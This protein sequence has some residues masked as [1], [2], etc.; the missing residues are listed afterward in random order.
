MLQNEA[1]KQMLAV[2]E[3]EL[4]H[5]EKWMNNIAIVSA[6]LVGCMSG[7]LSIGP[8]ELAMDFKTN[9]SFLVLS[10]LGI[11]CGTYSFSLYGHTTCPESF[12]HTQP[13]PPC[14]SSFVALWGLGLALGGPTGSV[15]KV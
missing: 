2:R 11:G 1:V 4:T 14:R 15:N 6:L 10:M 8:S 9:V 7:L 5:L 13:I 3:R 12:V